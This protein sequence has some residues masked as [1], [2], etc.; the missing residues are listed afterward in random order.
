MNVQFTCPTCGARLMA[1]PAG[2]VGTPI[3][4]K[5][6]GGGR[7]PEVRFVQTEQFGADVHAPPGRHVPRFDFVDQSHQPGS[8]FAGSSG[9][10]GG[11]VGSPLD[12]DERELAR[13]GPKSDDAKEYLRRRI[14]EETGKYD[15]R[16]GVD[17]LREELFRILDEK[18]PLPPVDDGSDK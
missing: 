2:P 18:H 11:E 12:K 16:M 9:P 8:S 5:C 13:L 14:E 4:R 17:S 10:M 3:R 15:G 6:D 1:P 7:H